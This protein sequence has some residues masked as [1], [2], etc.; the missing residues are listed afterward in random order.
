M[1]QAANRHPAIQ[2][3]AQPP[4]LRPSLSPLPQQVAADLAAL[5][6]GGVLHRHVTVASVALCRSGNLA[7]AR[8]MAHPYN[9]HTGQG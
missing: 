5:H 3:R 7:T 2:Q 4:P 1:S 6:D 8:L 9:V